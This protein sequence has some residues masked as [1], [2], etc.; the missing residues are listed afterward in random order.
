MD[1]RG[2]CL[3]AVAFVALC[4]LMAGLAPGAGDE[5]Q[6]AGSPAGPRQRPPSQSNAHASLGQ[7]GTAGAA[8]ACS[9]GLT[10]RRTASGASAR[11]S[12]R[13]S[14]CHGP[15][16]GPRHR[17]SASSRCQRSSSS[18]H[19]ACLAGVSRWRRQAA[20]GE[21]VG[22]PARSYLPSWDMVGTRFRPTLGSRHPRLA[23]PEP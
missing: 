14:G 10:G 1:L 19:T 7:P 6:A 8:P 22:S 15:P 13:G 23:R 11:I 4:V 16:S 21:L 9:A 3:E 12:L 17:Q 20:P 5:A 2:A 18:P